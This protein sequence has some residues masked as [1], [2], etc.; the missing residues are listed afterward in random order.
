MK[1]NFLF[2]LPFVLPLLSSAE[3]LLVNESE[4]PELS[5]KSAPFRGKINHSGYVG[6]TWVT[7]PHV[8]NPA[9]LGIDPMGRVFVAEAHRFKFGVPDLRGNRHMIQDDFKSVKVEDRLKM[10]QKYQDKRPMSWYTDY[11]ERLI[12]LEDKDGNMVADYRRLFSDQF[13]D[14][15]DGIGFSVLAEK[16]AVYFTCIPALRK[17]TDTNGDGIA[18]THEKLVEGFGVRVSFTGHDLHGII[19]G[20][21][22]RLYFTV[23]DRGFHVETEGGE[24]HQASGRGA[25]FR[26]DSDGSNFEV[27]AHGLRNPQEIAFDNYGNLFTF[28]NT[29]DIGDEARVVYVMDNSDSGWDMSHQ[30]P[31]QYVR[32]LDW[33]DFHLKQSVWVGEKMYE[34][35]NPEMPQWVFPPIAHAGNG[36]SG[37]TWLTG[38]SVPEDLRDSFLLTDYRGAAT[39]CESWVIKLEPEGSGFKMLGIESLIQGLAA[40]DVELGFDGNLYFADYG[41]GWSANRNGTV[42][43]LRPTNSEALRNG[44][45][46]ARMFQKGFSERSNIELSS[47]LES[48]DRRIRQ[49]AQFALVANGKNSL[50]VL[51]EHLTAEKFK[52]SSLHAVWA[53]GQLTRDGVGDASDLLLS[54]LQ[55]PHVEIRANAARTLGDLGISEARELL[56]STLGDQSSRVRSLSAIALGRICETGDQA[57]Q[58]ALFEAVAKN[59]GTDFEVT[60]RHAYLSALDRVCDPETLSSYTNSESSEQRMLAVLLLR[61]LEHEDLS[62]F[63]TDSDER[64]R[65]EAIRAIYDTKALTSSAGS[66]LL[67]IDLKDLPFFLQARDVTTAHR[68]QSPSGA[69]LLIRV[70][71]DLSLN[72]EIRMFALRAIQNWMNPPQFD[73]VLGH[74]RPLQKPKFPISDAS[75]ELRLDYLQFLAEERSG[76]LASL[77]TDVAEI[78]GIVLDPVL[79]RKQG[80]ETKLNSV[81]RLACLVNLAK[82]G[83]EEDND[84]FTAL[85]KDDAAEIQAFALKQCFLRGMDGVEKVALKA[86]KKSSLPVAREAIHQL[87]QTKPKK[88]IGFWNNRDREIRPELWLDLYTAM[89]KSESS[90][91]QKLGAAFVQSHPTGIHSLSLH[92]GNPVAGELVFNNQGACLQCHKING[93]GGL[94]GP[95]LSLVG[96]RLSREKL[97]ESLLYPSAEITPGYGLSSI[98]LNSGSTLAGRL[99]AEEGDEVLVITPDGENHQFARSEIKSISPPVSAMPPMALSLP[100]EELRD[101]IAYLGSRTKAKKSGSKKSSEH[102]K[103]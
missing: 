20:P 59:K 13:K 92:G 5:N 71:S 46:T 30:S 87:S 34:L 52:L 76:T 15:L 9:S 74:F 75:T 63:L 100:P 96:D 28:D 61:R 88:V 33:G 19:R 89:K 24:I 18:D 51:E 55:S 72:S 42:Q 8:E 41:G 38:L 23:G 90:E 66:K 60:L 80:M 64:I 47:L 39:K 98:A 44:A 45:E 7:Y 40:S 82:L 77:G 69:Q 21:D 93:E 12:I 17:L 36:P 32:D 43:V 99:A 103:K 10:Y 4:M 58:A 16:D 48:S 78:L 94:Q 11:P 50:S 81:V 97:L 86:V 73:S 31:H 68:C 25:V 14:A 56:L 26:C 83:L 49:E 35:F 27:Y 91:L 2:L 53:L 6:H 84:L 79:L 70:A 95:E 3:I 102:G 62:L 85:L 22:N 54:A 57:V 1:I 65:N 101:L 67:D 37:V 29:G